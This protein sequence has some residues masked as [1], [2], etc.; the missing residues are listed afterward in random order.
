M[1]FP[2]LFW[3]RD[4]ETLVSTSLTQNKKS[5]DFF[6]MK[7][8]ELSVKTPPEYVEPLSQIFLRY[9]HGGVAVERE[10]GFNPDE[11]ELPPAV[12]WVIVKTYIPLDSASDERRSQIDLGVRLVAHVS[13]ISPLEERVLDEEEWQNSW[14]QHFHVLHVGERTVIRPTWQEYTPTASEVV[15]A[16]DP[17]MAF[18]TGHHPTTRMCLELLEGLAAP[19]MSVLDVGCGSGI[20]SIAAAKLG[21]GRVLG[22][23]I[24]AVAARAARENVRENRVGRVV[25]IAQGSL[26]HPGVKPRS[27]DIAIANISAKVISELAPELARAV[28]PGGKVI[29]S[30]I[31]QDKKEGVEQALAASGGVLERTETDDDWV[32]LVFSINSLER[33]FTRAASSR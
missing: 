18:G 14:K 20:L 1:V 7:W 29:A 5:A 17:G 26:P 31:I 24:D 19:G 6:P 23:E 3:V 11:G 10:G 4:A 9:G 32:T 12:P 27:Y 2:F 30:G 22:V 25:R 15:V 21:A 13:P 16:L 33:R 8:L 28:R